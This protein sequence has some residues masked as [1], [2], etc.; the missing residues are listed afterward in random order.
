MLLHKGGGQPPTLKMEIEALKEQDAI[1]GPLARQVSAQDAVVV[2]TRHPRALRPARRH[3]QARSG[4]PVA[5]DG[6]GR[7]KLA[8]LRALQGSATGAPFASTGASPRVGAAHGFRGR[9]FGAKVAVSDFADFELHVHGR[10]YLQGHD[11][12]HDAQ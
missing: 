12:L 7:G 4:L 6:N 2:N 5:L 9:H 8:R 3:R 10:G 11:L 1:R